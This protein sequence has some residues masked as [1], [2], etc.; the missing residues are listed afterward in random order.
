MYQLSFHPYAASVVFLICLAAA[1]KFNNYMMKLHED[2]DKE[3]GYVRKK[4]PVPVPRPNEKAVATILAIFLAFIFIITI[5][6][7]YMHERNG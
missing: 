3:M 7:I 6:A 5:Y 1:V 4:Q 2:E